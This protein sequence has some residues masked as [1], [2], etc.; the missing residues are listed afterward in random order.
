MTLYCCICLHLRET[1]SEAYTVMNGQAVCEDHTG[2]VQG[3]L[4]TAALAEAAIAE[5]S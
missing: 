1:A 5:S 2:Y 3:G 4:F